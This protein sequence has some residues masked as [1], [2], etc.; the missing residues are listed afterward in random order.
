MN[1]WKVAPI[2]PWRGVQNGFGDRTWSRAVSS[3][4]LSQD[5]HLI[6]RPRSCAREARGTLLSPVRTYVRLWKGTKGRPLPDAAGNLKAALGAFL[7]LFIGANFAQLHPEP[8]RRAGLLEVD[9]VERGLSLLGWG[10][11]R[12]TG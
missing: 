1:F 9:V 2:D 11:G 8:G 5:A 4:V 3:S 10:E 6:F 12:S 7:V